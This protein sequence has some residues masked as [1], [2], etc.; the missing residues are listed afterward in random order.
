MVDPISC[1]RSAN[2]SLL[3]QGAVLWK[4]GVCQMVAP[5]AGSCG[6]EHILADELGRQK[7]SVQWTFKPFAT[8][9]LFP[10]RDGHLQT[11]SLF[12]RMI[13]FRLLAVCCLPSCI[14]EA[15]TFFDSQHNEKKG[16]TRQS[17]YST[18][19]LKLLQILF[20]RVT[21]PNDKAISSKCSV[22]NNI[23]CNSQMLVVRIIS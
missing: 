19:S 10:W 22:S 13:V 12:N 5:V 16:Q 3:C 8:S 20:Q 9:Q 15:N 2:G 18:N 1:Q 7:A 17:P 6:R 23:K 14:R 21:K 11:S 4:W